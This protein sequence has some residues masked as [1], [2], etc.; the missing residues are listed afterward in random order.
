MTPDSG[1]PRH[2]S[3]TVIKSLAV[4]LFVFFI[5]R[6][7]AVWL[8]ARNV[9]GFLAFLDNVLAAIAA[10]LVV[11]LYELRRQRGVDQLRESEQRFRLVADAAPV[12]IWMSGI[13]KLCTYFNKSWLD[14][15]GRPLAEELGNGWASGVHPDDFQRC[16]NTYTQSFDQREKFGMEYRLRRHDG[17]YRWIFDI[18]VPRYSQQGSF[19]GYIGSCIDITEQKQAEEARFR[20]TAIV[21]SSEDAI[22]SK[23]VDAVI[24]SW[25]T[26][27][28]RMF[29]Y[30]ESEAVGQ[31]ITVLIPR[32]L[33]DEEKQ[34]LE[35]LKAGKRIEHYET[36]RVTKTGKKVA[37]SLIISPIKDSTGRLV[38]FCKLAHDITERKQAEQVLQETNRALDTQTALLQSREELL[39]I[40][41]KNVPA[42]VA[43]FDRDM[44]YLQVSD[45]WCADFSLDSS[46]IIGYSHYEVFPDIPERWKQLLR[47]ALNGETLRADEDRWDRKDGT[48]WLRWEIRP[49]HNID[50]SPGGILI[51][52]ED[53]TRR[54][55]MEEALSGMSRKLIQAQE[56]ERARIAR[57][58]HDDITQRLAMLAIEIEKTQDHLPEMPSQVWDWVHELSM[59]TKE[60]SNDIQALSHEL[61]SSKLDYL[62]VAGGMKSWCNEFGE[63]RG[64]EIEFK[65]S[66]LMKSLAPEISLCLFR[67]LQEALHNAAKHSGVTRVDVQLWEESGEIQLIV[68]DSGIGFDV[69]ATMQDRGLGVT[70]MQERVRLVGGTIAIDSKP[71]GGTTVHVRVPFAAERSSQVT[72]G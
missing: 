27:A 18:G 60:I 8:T 56:Q 35:K 10:S 41:V 16:L 21:E 50:G 22:I 67:V 51:F 45:R 9:H 3:S 34:I 6:E 36:T 65:S 70:S 43:M 44:R 71:L 28:E 58:L 23:N 11:L 33:W 63:R 49:W 59:R 17:E 46:Q 25:N 30:T 7:M 72:A 40:F 52:S 55:Q 54:K 19:G 69:A 66:G 24:T 29:G 48:T 32:E 53:I 26:G 31:S 1:K 5:G 4:G 14:F 12:L 15:T 20:H 37:V 38:G 57:E 47:R 39:K 13:D 2:G 61:H 68:S 42:G 64:M 62:G